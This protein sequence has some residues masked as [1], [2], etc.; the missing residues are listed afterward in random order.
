MLPPSGQI[1][2]M[3]S[4][5]TFYHTIIEQYEYPSKT[6]KISQ[7]YSSNVVDYIKYNLHLRTKEY[8]NCHLSTDSHKSN[9]TL[10]SGCERPLDTIDHV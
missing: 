5:S 3:Q 7:T 10:W 8:T 1:C 6:N 9:M 4:L 2:V